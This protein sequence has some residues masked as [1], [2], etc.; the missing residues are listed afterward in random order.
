MKSNKTNIIKISGRVFKK[1]ASVYIFFL[2]FYV[3]SITVS[4]FFSNFRAFFNWYVFNL[5][6]I[7]MTIIFVIQL[8]SNRKE[9]GYSLLLKRYI[10]DSVF[11]SNKSF[12]D[13]IKIII[14]V[15]VVMVAIFFGIEVMDLALLIYGY[16]FL[17]QII[18]NRIVISLSILFFILCPIFIM[19]NRHFAHN[20]GAYIFLFLFT[21]LLIELRVSFNEKLTSKK[22]PV[23][24]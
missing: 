6:F 10:I 24:K 13:I 21:E 3:F 23:D 16:W 8:I 4:V 18:Q 19:V 15:F 11:S 2:L 5:L 7:L 9:G 14:F 20:L 17:L 22:Y 12:N 1:I